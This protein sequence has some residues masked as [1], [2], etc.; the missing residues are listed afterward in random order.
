MLRRRYGWGRGGKVWMPELRVA[1]SGLRLVDLGNPRSWIAR[2][3]TDRGDLQ[4]WGL[5][6]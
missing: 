1:W 2:S 4:R 5:R 6:G 3:A